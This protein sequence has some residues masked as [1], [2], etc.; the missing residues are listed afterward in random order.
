MKKTTKETI[1][2]HPVDIKSPP[3]STTV[4]I[5]S[6]DGISVG[7]WNRDENRWYGAIG[8]RTGSA[9]IRLN[10]D[11]HVSHWTEWPRGVSVF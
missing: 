1:N 5:Q 11:T 8:L 6:N 4:L 9:G 10:S 7:Y 2:W 3:H